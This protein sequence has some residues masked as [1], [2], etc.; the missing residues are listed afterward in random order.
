MPAQHQLPWIGL[1]A[2]EPAGQRR[3]SSIAARHSIRIIRRIC[4]EPGLL[5]I[6]LDRA[7]F[8][9]LFWITRLR[10][11]TL[12]LTASCLSPVRSRCGVAASR[13]K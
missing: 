6:D 3:R 9:G 12:A 8:A 11:L 4:L 5:V 1:S 2:S 13:P 10:L 7:S